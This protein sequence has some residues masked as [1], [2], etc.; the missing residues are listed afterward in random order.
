MC[1][2]LTLYIGLEFGRRLVC[3]FVVKE[4]SMY[5]IRLSKIGQRDRMYGRESV[6]GM[7]MLGWYI[8]K[9]GVKYV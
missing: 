1:F 3:E 4:M 6:V 9:Q 2:A 7:L 8:K 5:W